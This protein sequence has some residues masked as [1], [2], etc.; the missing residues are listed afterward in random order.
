MEEIQKEKKIID[1]FKGLFSG[2]L[3]Y[4]GLPLMI[5]IS[6]YLNS[7]SSDPQNWQ[8]TLNS[9]GSVLMTYAIVWVPLSIGVGV[10]WMNKG[11]KKALKFIGISIVVIIA[12][13]FLLVASCAL[14][15]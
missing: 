5:L 8:A 11:P 2:I 10:T 1:F 15:F 13:L 3:D 7:G 9:I 12:A 6:T 4:T 14:S